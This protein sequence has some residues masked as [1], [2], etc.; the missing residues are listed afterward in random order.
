MVN[1]VGAPPPNTITG[2][3][4]S[5]T[6]MDPNSPFVPNLA[7]LRETAMPPWHGNGY[8]AGDSPDGLVT[9]NGAGTVRTIDLFDRVTNSYIMST[10]S[11]SDGTYRFNGLSLS[12]QFDVRARGASSTE[13]DIIMARITSAISAPTLTGTLTP[14]VS[15]DWAYNSSLVIGGGIPPYSNPRVVSGALPTGFT[16]QVSG[17]QLIVAGQAPSAAEVDTFTLAVDSSDGQTATSASQ[18]ITT[19]NGYRYWR[20]NISA[21]NG[22]A[23]F[24]VI[25]ELEFRATHG[26]SDLTSPGLAPTRALASSEANSSNIA[27]YGFDDNSTNKWTANATSGWLRWDFGTETSVTEIALM[28]QYITGDQ[29]TFAPKDFIV[30]ASPDGVNWLTRKTVTGQTAWG[31]AEVRVFNW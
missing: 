18:T 9:F 6:K 13:N 5:Q 7:S 4:W 24:V 28:G 30:E 21:N 16:L 26:G 8:I 2:E 27:A 20:V 22:G 14:R 10:V 12:R 25:A 23:S 1:F 29:A 19:V 15:V 17:N 3:S 11:A 31:A